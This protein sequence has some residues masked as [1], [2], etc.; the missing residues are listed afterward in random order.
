MFGAELTKPEGAT[1]ARLR[2]ITLQH[3]MVVPSYFSI[4]YHHEIHQPFSRPGSDLVRG[5][6][7]DHCEQPPWVHAHN[8][9]ERSEIAHSLVKRKH[10]EC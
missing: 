3:G 6:Y 4:I 9:Q 7:T 1:T 10:L 5:Y 2:L 8:R